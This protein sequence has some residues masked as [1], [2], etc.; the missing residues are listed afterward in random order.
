MSQ[1][2]WTFVG[3][4]NKKYDVGLYHGNKSKH[5][6]VY[7]NQSP[8]IIDFSVNE[9]KSYHFYIGE[10][11]CELIIEKQK[12]NTFTYG[13]EIDEYTPTPLNIRRRAFIKRYWVW[14]TAM[15][16]GFFLAV[17]IITYLVSNFL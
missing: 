16:I 13:L 10:E 17:G 3:P 4:E 14:A 12:D 1:F 9:T 8:I 7:C 11:F 5:V 6:L 15:A 2:V